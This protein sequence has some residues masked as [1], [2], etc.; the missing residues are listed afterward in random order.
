M[1][2]PTPPVNIPGA[3]TLSVNYDHG[4]QPSVSV[5]GLK[6]V[7]AAFL[8]RSDGIAALNA[9]WTAMR[10]LSSST[11]TVTGAQF[12]SLITNG[13]VEELPPPATP[14]GGVGFANPLP[15]YAYLLKWSTLLGGR[16]GR[17]RTFLPGVVASFLSPD[18]R[19]LRS[20][21]VAP[22]SAAC[23]A[24]LASGA[25]AGGAMRPA[26]ISRRRNLSTAITGGVCSP[27]PG[28]QRRRLR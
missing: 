10:G 28:T 8:T 27:F 12:R 4:G 20:D 24:Y 11:V 17:G 16:S 22:A 25:F 19:Q 3:Y 15:S 1:T 7:G 13:T 18:G 23:A 6:A 21:A 9:W 26:I 2:V 14:G 5:L